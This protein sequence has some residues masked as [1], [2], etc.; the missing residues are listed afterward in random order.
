MILLLLY[1]FSDKKTMLLLYRQVK[2]QKHP[3]RSID[4]KGAFVLDALLK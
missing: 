4:G 2:K 3:V 1:I